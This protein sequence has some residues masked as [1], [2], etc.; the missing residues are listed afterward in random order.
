MKLSFDF[1]SIMGYLKTALNLLTKLLVG[2]KVVESEE[3][4]PYGE[5]IGYF[6]Q[7]VTGVKDAMDK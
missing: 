6:E 2:L 7:I 4:T 1:D 3:N 5:Y